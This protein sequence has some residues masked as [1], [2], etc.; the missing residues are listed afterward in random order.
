MAR[1]LLPWLVAAV[2]GAVYV[3][4]AVAQWRALETPSWDLGIF[5]Q[6]AQAYAHGAA[7]IVDIKG[8]GTHLLGDHWHPLLVVLGPVYRLWPSG[9]TLLVV[10]GALFAASAVPLTAVAI[11]RL[12]RGLGTVLGLAYALSW[13]LAAA[14]AAQFHEIAFA[15]PLL[16]LSLAAFLRGRWWACAAWA[17]PLVLVKE[18]LGLTVAALGAVL[19]WRATRGIAAGVL[20]WAGPDR[21]TPDRAAPDQ[22]TPDRAAPDRTVSP[23]SVSTAGPWSARLAAAVPALRTPAGRA[24]ALLI[25]WGT[26]WF[27]LT[28]LVLLP[29]FNAAGRWDYTGNLT[30]DPGS[31]GPIVN[32]F[33]G[34]GAKLTTLGLLAA[35]AGVV[36]LRSPL[37]WVWVPTLAWRFLGDVPFY[38][39]P[40]WHYS[41]VLMPVAAAALL[42]A[43]PALRTAAAERSVA[44]E[45][46]P[47]AV[48]PEPAE[49]SS[50][51][52]PPPDPA[53]GAAAQA[54]THAS[55]RI[56]ARRALPAA[57]VSV[58][59]LTTAA[60]LA[61]GPMTRL[62][63]PGALAW[64]PRAAAAEQVLGAIRPGAPVATDIGLM[65]YLVPHADVRWTGN[66][67]DPAPDYVLVDTRGATWGGNPPSDVAAWAGRVWPGTNYRPL[68]S[69]DG[70]ELAER[71]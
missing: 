15:V 47:A 54:P 57:A 67:T 69:V 2:A 19:W 71:D 16:A 56:R 66:T 17:M 42:D 41:A 29:A 28:I 51:A 43:L 24:G 30:G 52:T 46:T 39:G 59:A 48:K 23:L 5:T 12:G 34:P 9:L 32:L 27:V 6:L 62:A 55:R 1:V 33:S 10:Q 18:D 40:T 53:P 58:A 14:V 8:V 21:A 31:A 68:L 7:P 38:W 37:A 65:A 25:A 13:G 64:S 3:A 60:T 63:E 20:D 26:V 11:E 35:A 49:A 61:T 36:G 4:F 22:A 50:T 70:Y 44:R 45:K